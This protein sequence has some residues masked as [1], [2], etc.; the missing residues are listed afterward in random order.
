MKTTHERPEMFGVELY[1]KRF[2]IL[3]ERE[4][5]TLTSAAK[6]ICQVREKVINESYLDIELAS[7]EGRLDDLLAYQKIELT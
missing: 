3:N 6:I 4:R 5:K 1:D 7:I 2:L